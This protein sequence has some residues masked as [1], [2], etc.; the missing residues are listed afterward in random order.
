M[1]SRAASIAMLGASLLCGTGAQAQPVQPQNQAAAAMKG[2]YDALTAQCHSAIEPYLG[3]ALAGKVMLYDGAVTDAMKANEEI[4]TA[5]EAVLLRGFMIVDERCGAAVLA[6]DREYMPWDIPAEQ[7]FLDSTKAIYAAL[8]ARQTSFG[9]AMREY[10]N[11][12]DRL[13]DLRKITAPNGPALAAAQQQATQQCQAIYAAVPDRNLGGK[14]VAG[15]ALTAEALSNRNRPSEAEAMTVRSVR[16]A[17]DACA[18]LNEGVIKNYMPWYLPVLVKEREAD[19]DV[20]EALAD[21]RISF[22]EANQRLRDIADRTSQDGQKLMRD[23]A[24]KARPATPP[25]SAQSAPPQQTASSSSAAAKPQTPAQ[26]AFLEAS[27]RCA[28][29]IAPFKTG[30]LAGKIRMSHEKVTD[31]LMAVAEM[32][33]ETEAALLSDF[34]GAHTLC[35]AYEARF[36]AAYMP[37]FTPVHDRQ[38]EGDRQVFDALIARKLTYGEANRRFRQIEQ[39][40]MAE[41]DKIVAERKAGGGDMQAFSQML[42]PDN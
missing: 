4:P 24:A 42:Q 10:A 38:V 36:I 8:A 21:R 3:G 32:P 27:R 29:A 17:H 5:R 39:D 37:W 41:S 7:F 23:L 11:L 30:P 2:A 16:V 34:V 25:V 15:N 18:K 22:G 19:D 28:E 14:L 1:R 6:F 20:F 40:A 35:Q 26:A 33:S 13:K 31:A 9:K 12:L